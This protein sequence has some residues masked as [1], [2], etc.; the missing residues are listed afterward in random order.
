MTLY[1]RKL[2]ILDIDGTM[3]FAEEKVNLIY[4]QVVQHHHFELDQGSI[5]VWKRPNIDEFLE[6]CFEHYD[7]GIWSASSSEYVHSSLSYIIPDHLRSQIKFIWTSMRC[8]R[9]YQSRSSDTYPV[10]MIIKRLRKLWRRKSSA[11]DNP[12]LVN[13]YSKLNTLIVDDTPATY[14]ENYV[15]AIPITSYT[16]SL[17]DCELERVRNVLELLI[18][19][20][21]VRTVNKRS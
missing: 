15:N 2:L 14:Q 10:P 17:K 7:I 8:T 1:Q 4:K 9:K 20:N 21:D 13:T 19:S 5:C 18:S 11:S 6:W 12:N 3:I 16:G